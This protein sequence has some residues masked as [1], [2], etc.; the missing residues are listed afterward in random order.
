[1][2]D[3]IMA[4]RGTKAE[5]A[6]IAGTVYLLWAALNLKLAWKKAARGTNVDWIGAEL[7]YWEVQ[8]QM[9]GVCATIAKDKVD[10]LVVRSNDI[11]QNQMVERTKVK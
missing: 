6:R 8:Q 5:R 3:P 2:G 4:V 10:K 1:M 7:R 9:Q 11:L